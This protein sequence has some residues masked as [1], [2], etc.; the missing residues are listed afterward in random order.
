MKPI[1]NRLEC[2]YCIRNN[3]HGGECSSQRSP[4]DEKGCLIFKPDE[5]GC[6][7]ND[8]IKIPVPLYHDFP[9]L[10]TWCN[11]WQYKGVD[12]EI[13]INRIYGLRWNGKKGL[14]IVYCNCDYFVNE[15]HENYEE[16]KDKPILK[17]IK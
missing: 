10:N 9:L 8:D 17:L 2:A 13:K 3:S 5:R 14:L 11:D 4:Y 15:Y 6:I 16:T 1:P 7:R 12:T